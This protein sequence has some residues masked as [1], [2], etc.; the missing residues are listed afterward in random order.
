MLLLEIFHGF[1]FCCCCLEILSVIAWGVINI[2]DDN[3]HGINFNSDNNPVV[4]TS[5]TAEQNV[6]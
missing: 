6:A 1:F 3:L 5:V 4:I 2:K